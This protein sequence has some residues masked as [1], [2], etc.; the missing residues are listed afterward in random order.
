MGGALV[1]DDPSNRDVGGP[2]IG[3]ALAII[4]LVILVLA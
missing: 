2:I 1:N 4:A 3:M